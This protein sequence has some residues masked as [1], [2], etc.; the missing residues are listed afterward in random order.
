MSDFRQLSSQAEIV[1]RNAREVIMR[2]IAL[3]FLLG[4]IVAA[5]T[6]EP[7]RSNRQTATCS[8]ANVLYRPVINEM[9]S[10][11][12]GEHPYA[13]ANGSIRIAVH[14]AWTPEFFVDVRLNRKGP[15][16]LTL[17][18]LPKGAKTVTVLL[19]KELKQHP[20][21][22][23]TSL[24]KTLPVQRKTLQADNKVERLITEFFN[25]R[26]EPRRIPDS[27]RP[28]A[29]EYE[30]VYIGGDTL[31]F[32]SDDYETPTVRWIESFLAA[33]HDAAGT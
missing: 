8:S 3:V 2:P 11:D 20:S 22:D 29:T 9:W 5:Q 30:L 17:Y 23:A 7:S 1:Y 4:I 24:A 14:P 16:T 15:S 10:Q 31:V 12:E 25:L 27:V 32:N 6:S 19:E 28:D 18:S 13:A 21:T 33:I 26:W